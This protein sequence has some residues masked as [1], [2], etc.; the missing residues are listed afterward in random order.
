M[1]TRNVLVKDV[2]HRRWE[3]R[4]IVVIPFLMFFISVAPAQ[5]P[6]WQRTN[7]PYGGEVSSLG[8]DST[9]II[10]AGQT[11]ADEIYRSTR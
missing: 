9:G 5:T 10:V 7:G 2:H 6:F 1:L 8:V 11:G 4:K 3:M